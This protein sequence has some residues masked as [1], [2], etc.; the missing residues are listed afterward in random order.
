MVESV[1]LHTRGNQ[2]HAG[3]ILGMNRGTVRTHWKKARQ[4]S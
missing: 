1:L 2:Q 3:R 4:Y